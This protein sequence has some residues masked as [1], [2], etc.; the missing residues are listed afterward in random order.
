MKRIVIAA[1]P[2]DEAAWEGFDWG[3][4]SA[5]RH[6]RGCAFLAAPGSPHV[7]TCSCGAYEAAVRA[8]RDRKEVRR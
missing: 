7:S 1:A 4:T 5:D 2:R 6:A 3:V 8:H